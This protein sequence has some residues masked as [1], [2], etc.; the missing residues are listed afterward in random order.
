[1]MASL[2]WDAT[3]NLTPAE[4]RA[5]TRPASIEPESAETIRTR[6]ESAAKYESETMRGRTHSED[7][8]LQKIFVMDKYKTTEID[9]IATRQARKQLQDAFERRATQVRR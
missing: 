5:Q 8:Q 7:G 3:L 9:W 2:S 4:H 1:M 6:E